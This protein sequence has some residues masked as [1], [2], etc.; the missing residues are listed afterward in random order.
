MLL[1]RQ[2]LA[3]NPVL[4]HYPNMNFKEVEYYSPED[5]ICGQMV[6]VWGRECL[7]Y[8]A[9]TFTKDWYAK[10]TGVN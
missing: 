9:D 1:R 6:T 8:D 4:T 2:K 7:I 10:N 5:L 3:K